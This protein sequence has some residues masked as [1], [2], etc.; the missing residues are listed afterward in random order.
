[1]LCVRDD[2]VGMPPTGAAVRVGLGTSIVQAL[3]K[4]LDASVE[5]APAQPGAKVSIR[6]TQIA[7]VEDE[8]EIASDPLATGQ[9]PSRA[10][11]G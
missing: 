3:A 9:G 11:S 8:Q 7:M 5:V 6:H 4:Q 2:G 1:V 10:I